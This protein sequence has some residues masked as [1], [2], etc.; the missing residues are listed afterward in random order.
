M[1]TVF[2]YPMR[3]VIKELYNLNHLHE[4]LINNHQFCN[5]NFHFNVDLQDSLL[6][7][8][9]A[10]AASS[11]ERTQTYIQ[12]AQSFLPLVHGYVFLFEILGYFIDIIAN[13]FLQDKI[14]W[15]SGF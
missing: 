13:I 14:R 4:L 6:V 11:K 5:Y 9:F 3:K 12:Y 15:L 1:E 2:T 7:L 8:E 10:G